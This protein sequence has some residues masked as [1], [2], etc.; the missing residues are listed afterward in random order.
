MQRVSTYIWRY[1]HSRIGSGIAK[2]N[3]YHNPL[4]ADLTTRSGIDNIVIYSVMPIN[5]LYQRNQLKQVPI[6]YDRVRGLATFKGRL[7]FIFQLERAT[8]ELST[9]DLELLTATAYEKLQEVVQHE[10]RTLI[11]MPSV[12]TSTNK[13]NSKQ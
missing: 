4:D 10:N 3:A 7:K 9:E 6:D 11:L 5:P 2:A 1:R 12:V 8:T 13:A